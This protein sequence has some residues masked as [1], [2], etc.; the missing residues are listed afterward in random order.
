MSGISDALKSSA[1]HLLSLERSLG[2]IQS[3]VGNASTQGYARQDVGS[4]LDSST[5]SFLQ[6]SSRDDF[7]EQAVRRQSSQLG[8][9]DQL[10]SVLDQ[11]EGNFGASGDA[12]I[13]KSISNLFAT[14]SALSTNPNDTASRQL[15]IDRARQLARSFNSTSASL[16]TTLADSRR[17]VS[18]TVDSINHLAGL[19]RD[20]NT[21]QIR[22]A[23]VAGE[24]SVDA[25]LHATLEQLSEFADVQALRQ[26]DGTITLLLG[27]Q[28]AIVVGAKQYLI[29]ADVT[30]APTVS[31]QD[32]AGVDI[33]SQISGGRLSGGLKAINQALPGYQDGLNQLAQG[34]A[35][36]V[37]A[38]L[39]AGVDTNGN[40]GAP[41]FSY[42]DP[43]V[44]ATFTVTAI[45]AGE[46]A[47]ATPGAPGGN[48]NAL[49]LSALETSPAVNGLTYARAY[50]KISAAV[51]REVADARDSQDFQKQ[52]LSQ[53][54]ERR[55]ES[56]GV[57]LDEEAIR[58][59]EYQRAYQ[60]TAR[61][62]SILDQLSQT[63]ID[64]I[65]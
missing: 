56:S 50:G 25:K 52:L 15:V 4:A 43:N 55:A 18:A 22:N 7:A 53:A 14:F 20:F 57:S 42:T 35:D 61:L 23:D 30:S 45:T 38:V 47:A 9:F 44:S 11:V 12:E 64:M 17:Q 46:L 26:T 29:Q 62:V 1:S 32:S 28:T 19:V 31:I 48:G 54:R 2:L 21:S 36:S 27:G 60:A 37:N 10:A 24:S 39:A 8:H 5:D 59:V 33:T 63:T 49:A 41:L 3:N 58:L 13:P 65:R 51:G 16:G 6:L 34:I 40:A